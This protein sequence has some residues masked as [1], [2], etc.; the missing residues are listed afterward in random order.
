MY[1][2]LI[3]LQY[4][5]ELERLISRK[6]TFHV[7]SN[8]EIVELSLRLIRLRREFMIIFKRS[9]WDLRDVTK[10]FPQNHLTSYICSAYS[11]KCYRS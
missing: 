7:A 3:Y 9:P 10:W 11:R 2:Y 4:K 5:N 6:L 8:N 1:C